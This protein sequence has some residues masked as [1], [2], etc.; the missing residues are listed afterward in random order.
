LL[1]HRALTETDPLAERIGGN[2]IRRHYPSGRVLGDQGGFLVEP[3]CQCA[4]PFE[5]GFGIR[6]AGNLMLGIEEFRDPRQRILL[7]DDIGRCH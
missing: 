2:E 7:T 1:G 4:D 6:T 3:T 5:V